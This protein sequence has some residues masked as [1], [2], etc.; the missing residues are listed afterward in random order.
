MKRSI[1]GYGV[2]EGLFDPTEKE[3]PAYTFFTLREDAEEAVE[4][5]PHGATLITFEHYE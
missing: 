5:S 1:I 2:M 3:D 4:N